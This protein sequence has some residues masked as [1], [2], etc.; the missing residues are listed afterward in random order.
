MKPKT[1]RS[2]KYMKFVRGLEC[3][4]FDHTCT[5][6][7]EDDCQGEIIPHH[8]T[9]GGVG[10]KGPDLSCIPLCHFHHSEGHNIGWDS[11][12]DKHGILIDWKVREANQEYIRV[13]EEKLKGK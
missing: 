4:V 11:F 12:E 7:F 10:L 13:L 2:K 5:V 8:T 1:Y 3:C 9:G 6:A